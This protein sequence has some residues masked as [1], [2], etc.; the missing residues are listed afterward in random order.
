ME[1]AIPEGVAEGAQMTAAFDAV[2]QSGLARISDER[3]AGLTELAQSLAG[4]PLGEVATEAARGLADGALEPRHVATLAACRASIEGARMDALLDHAAQTLGVTLLESPEQA[5]PPYSEAAEALLPGVQQ[6]LMELALAGLENTEVDTLASALALLPGLQSAPE[7]SRLATLLTLWLDEMLGWDRALDIPARR[8]GDLFTQALLH[9]LTPPALLDEE[10]VDGALL[11]FGAELLHGPHAYQLLV[12]GLLVRGDE[13]RLVRVPLSQWKVD[14]LTGAE[15][16]HVLHAR[17]PA[18]LDAVASPAELSVSGMVLRASGELSWRGEV[19]GT[20][21]LAPSDLDL[22]G[23]CYARPAARDRHPMQ[24]ALPIALEGGLVDGAVAGL[25][26][27]LDRTSPWLDP[28]LDA[29]AKATQVYGLLRFDAD[30]E[31]Q[32]L[33]AA[34]K[35][36]WITPAK[37][38][39]SGAKLKAPAAAI[40][41]ERASRLLR[42]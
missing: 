27:N 30:W 22:T 10:Q 15:V 40:L 4:T 25:A 29:M 24:L 2:L 9:T 39:A 7:L 23:A 13:R 18:L 5:T 36:K 3:L 31:I 21:A 11:V 42:R 19:T 20:T 8:W 35:K 12:H 32:P 37:L 34:K 17:A 41:Q 28:G 26:A 14:A 38:I 1:F 6:W 33:C 16:M